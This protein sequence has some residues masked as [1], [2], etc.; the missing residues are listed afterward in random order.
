MTDL[1][2]WHKKENGRSS[3]GSSLEVMP[4]QQTSVELQ[5]DGKVLCLALGD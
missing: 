3:L 4:A 5:T 1:T 2:T